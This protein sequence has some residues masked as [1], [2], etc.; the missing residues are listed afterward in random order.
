MK[1]T[2]TILAYCKYIIRRESEFVLFK[3]KIC[4]PKKTPTKQTK[5]KT[6]RIFVEK[7]HVN[8]YFIYKDENIIQLGL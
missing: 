4:K 5:T 1:Y 8:I 7:I 3:K 2:Y 6:K